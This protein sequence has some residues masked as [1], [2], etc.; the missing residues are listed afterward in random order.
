MTTN[1]KPRLSLVAALAALTTFVSITRGAVISTQVVVS[2]MNRPCFVTA[3]PGDTQRLFIV[4]RRGAI[5]I[6]DLTTS[7]LLPTPFLDIDPLVIAIGSNGEE[8]GMLGLAFHPD[9]AN[10]GFFYVYYIDI[11]TAPGDSIVARYTVS[12]AD[13][14]LADPASAQI[15]LRVDQPTPAA[16]FP[17]HKA[18]WI[19][20]GPADGYLYIPFGDGGNACDP[21]QRA[22]DITDQLLGKMLRVDI[23]GQDAF[24]ADPNKNYAIPADNPFVGLTGD[25]EIWAY[26][27]RNP[28][29]CSFD[30]ATADLYIG[31]VGQDVQEEVDYQAAGVTTAVNYGWDCE[32]GN[33]CSSTAPSSCTPSGC[34]CGAASLQSPVFAYSQGASH[35]A[36]IGG[37]V[38]RGNVIPGENGKY[39]YGDLCSGLVWSFQVSGG[40]AMGNVQRLS[41][42]TSLVSFGEGGDGELY[43]VTGTATNNGVVRRIIISPAC[44]SPADINADCVVNDTDVQILVSVLLGSPPGDP[45]LQA[46]SDVN[47]DT[48]HDGHDVAAFVAGI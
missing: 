1:R 32:E 47:G 19:G 14:N 30:K 31:D 22:Q 20:F 23:D 7:T 42:M 34:T 25:D 39:F 48:V 11:S 4:E 44:N 38:Y 8:R 6:F 43:I 21:G 36:V 2:A 37:Y 29:R 46:R 26:G 12:A 28:Y 18:G 10:N 45:A 40:V 27:L 24:P 3:P 9:Y 15:V 17:N 5:R 41:G 16:S 13:A 35:C 33:V